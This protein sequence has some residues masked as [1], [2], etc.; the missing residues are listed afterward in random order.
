M[1]RRSLIQPIRACLA[2]SVRKAA[3]AVASRLNETYGKNKVKPFYIAILALEDPSTHP[4]KRFH[5]SPEFDWALFH[6]D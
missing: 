1:P 5:E 3:S 4:L 2:T 6:K